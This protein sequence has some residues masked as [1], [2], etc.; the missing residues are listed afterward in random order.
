[1]LRVNPFFKM[2]CMKFA[3]GLNRLRLIILSPTSSAEANLGLLSAN[4]KF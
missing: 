1:M 4:I 3:L 2:I